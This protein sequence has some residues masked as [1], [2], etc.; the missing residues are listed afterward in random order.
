M[1]TLRSLAAALLLPLL[2]SCGD[3]PTE[4]VQAPTGGPL[5][6]TGGFY[7][8]CTASIPVGG[9]GHCSAYSFGGGFSYPTSWY[10]S[11]PAVASVSGGFVFGRA[12]GTA[13]I[14]AY[15]N[16][17]TSSST[18]YVYATARDRQPGDGDLRHGVPGLQRAAHRQGL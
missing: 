1:R 5:K 11:N 14:T 3:M 8:N 15:G 7:I 6:S 13:R 17:Y 9:S 4:Q 2:A 12:P 16:G 10:S 18:V